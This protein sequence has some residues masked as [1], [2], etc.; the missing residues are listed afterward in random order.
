M[1][2]FRSKQGSPQSDGADEMVSAPSRFASPEHAST[3]Q[4]AADPA[5]H[6]GRALLPG[7]YTELEPLSAEAHGR[8]RLDRPAEDFSFARSAHLTP[9]TVHEIAKAALAYPVVFDIATGAPC[10]V[11]GIR[12]GQNLVIDDNGALP[13]D[14]YAPRYLRHYP[15][16][17]VQSEGDGPAV[18]HIDRAAPY[19][20][21]DR[22]RLLFEE[23][24]PSS[25]VA[26]VLRELTDLQA[27]W[28]ETL[29]FVQ[30]LGA[31]KLLEPMSLRIGR[32]RRNRTRHRRA[33]HGAI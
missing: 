7:L 32:N 29:R 24:R 21:K 8:L 22:G 26:A 5:M 12:V 1:S 18:L 3:P 23:G 20:S 15:F 27:Q 17:L 4:D 30:M 13:A 9:L 14:H 6:S 31:A 2:W 11:M 28:L 16:L 33:G 19:L 10:A 25:L